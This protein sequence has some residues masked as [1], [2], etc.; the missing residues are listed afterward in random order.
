MAL[1]FPGSESSYQV[2]VSF[3]G[4]ASCLVVDSFPRITCAPDSPLSRF[5]LAFLHLFC[6]M[7]D[8]LAVN[9][10]SEPSQNHKVDHNS[11]KHTYYV[12][13]MRVEEYLSLVELQSTTEALMPIGL[14]RQGLMQQ[15]VQ[16]QASDQE[17]FVGKDDLY[18]L[19]LVTWHLW[20]SLQPPD[21]IERAW[22]LIG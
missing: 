1:F 13:I 15:E 16:V 9:E 8:V 14:R 7:A 18:P 6:H 2:R 20:K 4:V 17:G 10:Q 19:M 11:A 3:G 22:W 5:A 21:G 12:A